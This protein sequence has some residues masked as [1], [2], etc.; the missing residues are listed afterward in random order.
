[1][2]SRPA[3]DIG[4]CWLSSYTLEVVDMMA[5]NT[6]IGEDISSKFG[7]HCSGHST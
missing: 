3:Q 4:T 6:L 5:E 7:V 2:T 1:M